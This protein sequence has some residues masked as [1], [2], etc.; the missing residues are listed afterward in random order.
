M[1]E[2]KKDLD[3]IIDYINYLLTHAPEPYPDCDRCLELRN[4]EKCKEGYKRL[5]NDWEEQ[6]E[7]ALGR[8][9]ECQMN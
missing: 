2:D 4:C 6:M 7:N 1:T 5:Q 8:L 9:R 3:E